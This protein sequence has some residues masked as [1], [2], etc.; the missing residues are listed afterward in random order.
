MIELN[1]T[2]RKRC[3][4][5]DKIFEMIKSKYEKDEV[6]EE[7]F[8]KEL[9]ETLSEKYN[10]EELS[11][12]EIKSQMQFIFAIRLKRLLKEK[13]IKEKDFAKLIEIRPATI[14]RYIKGKNFPSLANI[15][16]ICK[17]LEVSPAYL[18]GLPILNDEDN[19]ILEIFSIGKLDLLNYSKEYIE[20][21]QKLNKSEN[22]N[23]T[24]DELEEIKNKIQK[25]IFESLDNIANKKGKENN[26]K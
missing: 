18:L 8:E 10:I 24:D 15:V 14:T 12:E 9:L 6:V 22:S 20:I 25:S 4:T 13:E 1:E 21:K 5:S 3:T 26:Q 2:E 11:T 23:K 7:D 17:K 19:Q 16:R